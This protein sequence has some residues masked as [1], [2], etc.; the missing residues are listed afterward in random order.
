[1]SQLSGIDT[2]LEQFKAD[3]II[4]ED[5]LIGD[6]D[7]S[8]MVMTDDTV[9]SP[10][11]PVERTPIEYPKKARRKGITGYVV[12][13]LLLDQTGRVQKVKV[14][15]SK[16]A[17]VFDDVAIASVKSWKFK[18]AEYQGKPVKVWAKQKIRFELN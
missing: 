10:P 11:K 13:N 7:K 1:M 4:S 15:E 9:D 8:N 17:G 6:V 3:D 18:P 2:G 16:P 12:L 14:L 5:S